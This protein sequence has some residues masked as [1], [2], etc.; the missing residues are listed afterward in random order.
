[1]REV[2]VMGQKRKKVAGEH[3]CP[4]T[5]GIQ[6]LPE[7]YINRVTGTGGGLMENLNKIREHGFINREDYCGKWTEDTLNEEIG[8]YFNFCADKDVKPAKAGLRLWLGV[9]KSQYWEWEKNF[10]DFK[11]NLINEAN[12]LM[13]LEYISRVEKYPTG[14]MFLLKSS[15]NHS[16]KQ[17]VEITS[18]D[19]SQDEI[20]N[21]VSKMGLDK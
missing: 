9:S 8:K 3:S 19:V 17:E 11:A 12:D 10:T 15:H 18:K 6:N 1:M 2:V 5:S 16:D 7:K 4:Q 20:G 13:E 21:I 14:N